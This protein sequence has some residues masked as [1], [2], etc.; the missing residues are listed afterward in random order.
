MKAYRVKKDG[1]VIVISEGE[2]VT[3]ADD[4]LFIDQVGDII[5]N[6]CFSWC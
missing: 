4:I 5:G 1:L 6:H 3:Y 2:W